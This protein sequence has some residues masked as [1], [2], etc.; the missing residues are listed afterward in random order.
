M[1][2]TKSIDSMADLI[3]GIDQ[4]QRE[5]S[6]MREDAMAGALI[7]GGFTEQVIRTTPMSLL[8]RYKDRKDAYRY[9]KQRL[10]LSMFHND[11]EATVGDFVIHRR[12]DGVDFLFGPSP[13]ANVPYAGRI[14]ESKVPATEESRQV[15]LPSGRTVWTAGWSR[16]GRASHYISKPW[17]DNRFETERELVKNMDAQL[18]Q[19]GLM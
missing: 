8:A 4:V 6:R 2:I 16:A 9:G 18:R 7:N 13:S 12:M 3:L 11:T 14:H 15:K 17:D 1:R 10:L 19:R 5:W